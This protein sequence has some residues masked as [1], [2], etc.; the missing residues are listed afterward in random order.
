[1]KRRTFLPVVLGFHFAASGL[2]FAQGDGDEGARRQAMEAAER[3]KREKATRPAPAQVQPARPPEQRRS[4]QERRAVE[5]PR[6]DDRRGDPRYVQ[7]APRNDFRHDGRQGGAP[8]WNRDGRPDGHRDGRW[9]GHR[10]GNR[11]GYRDDPRHW[12]PQTRHDWRGAGP[13]YRYYRGDHL[14]YEYRQRRYV[15]QDWRPYY[16]YAPPRGYY[17]VHW[18]DD[19]LLVE[20][21]TGLIVQI[22][23]G[24]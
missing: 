18:G 11:R 8:D 19:F 17:W 14:P 15:I 3:A 4:D 7:E 16:L 23:L 10:D 20:V 6:R 13:G 9:D 22:L 2:A 21:A 1:M 24:N 5:G 12:G